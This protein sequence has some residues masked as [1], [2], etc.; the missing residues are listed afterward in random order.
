MSRLN[1][2]WFRML[3]VCVQNPNTGL[4]SY[5]SSV[6]TSGQQQNY[7]VFMTNTQ[8]E[9]KRV[10]SFCDEFSKHGSSLQHWARSTDR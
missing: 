4:P 9:A 2:L 3:P 6:L 8:N 1:T 5:E 10:D 7:T